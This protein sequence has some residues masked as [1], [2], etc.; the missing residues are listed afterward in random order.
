MKNIFLFIITIGLL[1]TSCK[2][3]DISKSENNKELERQIL[4]ELRL[5]LKQNLDD[6]NSNIEALIISKNAN[7]II[8]SNME[9]KI[10]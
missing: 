1:M 3:H 2:N 10:S 6:I 8:I 9:N 7:E 4:K 5:E